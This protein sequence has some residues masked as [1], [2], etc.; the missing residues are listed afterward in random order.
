MS[1]K[2]VILAAGVGI[3]LRPLTNSRPK[4]LVD[5]QGKPILE[6]QLESLNK[7]GINECVVIVGYRAE[8]IRRRFGAQFKGVSLSFVENQLYAETNNLYSL[9]LA[10]EELKDDILL[11]E[12]DLVFENALLEDVLASGDSD[13]AVVDQYRTTMDGTVIL[14]QDGLAEAMVLKA[15][16]GHDFDYRLALKTVNI[17]KFSHNTLSDLVIPELGNFVSE[18]RTDQYYEAV[19][20]DLIR[21]GR[22]DLSVL[23]VESRKWAEIDTV[24][25]LHEAEGISWARFWEEVNGASST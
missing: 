7:M 18:K 9:W 23:H 24:E 12:G 16:Q 15:N 3:R 20:A 11:L 6:Y 25:D 2:A 1:M 13:V 5:V 21:R 10:K 22:L 4:C 19:L 17:Y 8:Q 14:A